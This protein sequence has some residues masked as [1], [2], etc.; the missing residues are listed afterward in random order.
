MGCG[1]LG[2]AADGLLSSCVGTLQPTQSTGTLL[3]VPICYCA[4]CGRDVTSTLCP[5]QG[6]WDSW[7]E[8]L[9]ME[10]ASM[11]WAALLVC[12]VCI[13][14]AFALSLSVFVCTLGL[15][16]KVIS[17]LETPSDASLC[18]AP[19]AA[20]TRCWRGVPPRHSRAAPSCSG[21]E[22]R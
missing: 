21:T 17:Q 9:A 2:R 3:A 5:T 12:M 14:E 6:P 16:P 7:L 15:C 18:Q 10:P 8:L 11:S 1:S 13:T 22:Q 4:L 20:W 19:P